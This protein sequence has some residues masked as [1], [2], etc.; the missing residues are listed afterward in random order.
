MI[1]PSSVS[2]GGRIPDPK[3]LHG[4]NEFVLEVLVNGSLNQYSGPAEANLTLI[5]ERRPSHS[6]DRRI[7]IAIAK[8]DAGVLPT[9]F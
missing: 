1:A 8:N 4:L 7:E 2:S 5:Q 3:V 6:L 9:E